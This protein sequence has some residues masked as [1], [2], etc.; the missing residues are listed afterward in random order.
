[1]PNLKRSKSGVGYVEGKSAWHATGDPEAGD[2]VA[3]GHLVKVLDDT[4]KASGLKQGEAAERLGI[5]QPNLSRIL[6]GRFRSVTFDQLFKLLA[7]MGV[8]VRVTLAPAAAGLPASV[9]V[10]AASEEARG[11]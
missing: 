11:A 1:M 10:S 2:M 7:G 9:A 5:P 8:D 4:I 6:S 3:K